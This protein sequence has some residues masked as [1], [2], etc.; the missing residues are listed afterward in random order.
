M[1]NIA[2]VED[3]NGA[4]SLLQGYIEQYAEKNGQEFH[5]DRFVE[6]R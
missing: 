3:E 4:A 6:V 1:R 5:V 2:I